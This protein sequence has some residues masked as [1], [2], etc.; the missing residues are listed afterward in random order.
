MRPGQA[1]DPEPMPKKT[2]TQRASGSPQE[3]PKAGGVECRFHDHRRES[4]TSA[5]HLVK[6]TETPDARK[7][8]TDGLVVDGLLVGVST[9]EQV[10]GLGRVRARAF[11]TGFPTTSSLPA[12]G[13]IRVLGAMGVN[14]FGTVCVRVSCRRRGSSCVFPASAGRITPLPSPR[15]GFDDLA[16]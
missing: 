8:T 1:G 14:P 3:A 16:L 2:E 9:I 7:T 5:D 4:C 10:D 12:P 11:S 13:K 15:G 6:S